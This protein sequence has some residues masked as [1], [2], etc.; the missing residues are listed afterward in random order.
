VR[1]NIFTSP[2]FGIF[3][4]FFLPLSLLCLLLKLSLCAHTNWTF[5]E[6]QVIRKQEQNWFSTASIKRKLKQIASRQ[7]A[8]LANSKLDNPAEWNLIKCYYFIAFCAANWVKCTPLIEFKLPVTNQSVK[9]S[10]HYCIERVMQLCEFP[11][12]HISID[13][14]RHC[15]AI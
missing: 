13:I 14:F 8:A 10:T 15:T 6:T 1:P 11:H 9:I 5:I 12:V 4:L 7:M 3:I 2:L